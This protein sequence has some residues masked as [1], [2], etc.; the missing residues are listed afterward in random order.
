[1]KSTLDSIFKVGFGVELNSLSGSDDFGS[2]FTKA[3]EDV[4]ASVY[5]RFVDIFW[6]LKRLLNIGSEAALKRN[7]KVMD[8]FVFRLIECK[9]EQQQMKTETTGVRKSGSVYIEHGSLSYVNCY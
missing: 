9:R 1:M 6:K 7:V 5:W 4:N 2:Q 8:D 3:F